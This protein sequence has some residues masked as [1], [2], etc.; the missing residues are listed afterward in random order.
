[1]E[2]GS[3]DHFPEADNPDD[4]VTGAR[5]FLLIKD[6]EL[7]TVSLGMLS[8]LMQKGMIRLQRLIQ[9]NMLPFSVADRQG[10][11]EGLIQRDAVSA[12]ASARAS[13]SGGLSLSVKGLSVRSI[14]FSEK[15]IDSL[16]AHLQKIVLAFGFSQTGGR[17]FGGD[18]IECPKLQII[19][20][21]D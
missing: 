8:G 12:N 15:K 19:A 13:A 18:H 10:K 4:E 14:A 9:Q 3:A 5:I 1:M 20:A 17:H 7:H 6:I 11:T 2:K 16:A 21:S